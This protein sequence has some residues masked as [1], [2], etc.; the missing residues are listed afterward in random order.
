MAAGQAHRRS[1][2][3]RPRMGARRTPQAPPPGGDLLEGG[4][5]DRSG[6]HLL[7]VRVAR[8]HR[9]PSGARR[10]CSGADRLH[11]AGAAHRGGGGA[12][13]RRPRRPIQQA[14]AGPHRHQQRAARRHDRR[15]PGGARI[16][17]GQRLRSD[18]LGAGLGRPDELSQQDRA[19][20]G[21]DRAARLRA[22]V[23]P[24]PAR[25]LEPADNGRHRPVRGG[26]QL[27][28]RHGPGLPRRLPAGGLDLPAAT[29]RLR[30][31]RRP[32][33]PPSGVALQ[34]PGRPRSGAPVVCVPGGPGVLHLRAARGGARL[35]G[36]RHHAPL[37][38]PP[39]VPGLR[40]AP[41]RGVQV[42]H[43][44]GPVPDP[45]RRSGVA[46]LP[47][48]RADRIHAARAPRHGGRGRRPR[49]ADRDL[50]LHPWRRPGQPV[51]RHR[52]GRLGSRGPGGYGDAVQ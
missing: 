9:R 33:R 40:R 11:Q 43:G 8:G 25:G 41:D 52:R 45:R 20:P 47:G 3:L 22:Q 49:S 35:S 32:V 6:N 21:P 46:A 30:L 14:A 44:P 17:P 42:S 2:L 12:G 24:L 31:R 4:R 18:P 36:R 48:R 5:S 13:A 7:P 28:A 19:H 23:G 34:G 37:Q 51:L 50:R 15:D 26:G 16:V 10:P 38:P 39:A 1:I 29:A 27:R